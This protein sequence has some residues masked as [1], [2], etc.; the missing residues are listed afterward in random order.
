MIIQM[1]RGD[2]KKVKFCVKDKSKNII[3]V[4]FDNIFITFKKNHYTEDVLFQKTLEN[5]DIMKDE[6]NYYHFFI[7]PND[8]DELEYKNYVFDI[9]IL[10]LESK[11]KQT[12]LGELQILEEVTFTSNEGV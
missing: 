6:E 8:T 3:D 4:D 11:I 2:Y 7:E 9:E 5:K 1:R 12:I 10:K